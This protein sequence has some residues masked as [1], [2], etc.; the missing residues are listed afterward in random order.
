MNEAKQDVFGADVIVI[1]HA[2][3]FLGKHNYTS[4]SVGKPLEH[5]NSLNVAFS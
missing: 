5:Q 1:E 3:L 2:C 4:G